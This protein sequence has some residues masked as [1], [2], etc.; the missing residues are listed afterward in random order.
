MV[1][2]TNSQ[3][4][5]RS[6]TALLALVWLN[7]FATAAVQ[8]Q[9][10]TPLLEQVQVFNSLPPA[11]Q[12]ALI[13]ELQSQL[14]P[15]QRQAI[16]QSL[17]EGGQRASQNELGASAN[18]EPALGEEP[19]RDDALFEEPDLR[20]AG[21]DTVVIQ[22]VSRAET[23]NAAETEAS[24]AG[25]EF[26]Q[27]LANANPYEL[28]RFGV[29]Y[30]PGV[31]AIPLAGL[32]V[33]EAT[34]RV[35]AEPFLSDFLITMT[36]LPLSPV[37]LEALKPFGYEIFEGVPSA[38]A[39]ATDIPVPFD[40][41]IGPGDTVYVQL[42]GNQNVEY[43][44]EVSREGV[45]NFPE[46]G[47]LTVSG[48]SFSDLRDLINERVSEQLIGVRASTT[49]GELRSI[50]IFVLGEV[51][52][53]GSYTVSGLSTM[54]NA[55]FASGGI[56]EI[57]SMRSIA[58][59]RNGD[60]VTTLD[61]YD[62]LLRGNTSGD[63]RLQPGDVIFVRPVGET[64]AVDGEVRRPAIYELRNER[65][66][67]AVVAL[68]GGLN[69]N[70]DRAAVKLER[71][72]P[73]RGSSVRDIDLSVS[74]GG[75]VTVQDG[76]VLRVQPNIEQLE[77]SMRLDGNVYQPGLYEWREGMTLGD[78]LPGPN[79]VLP[80]T[81]INYVLV[82]REVRPNVE[83]DVISADL[84]EIWSSD[85]M[86]GDVQ[87]A[88]R[89]TV[90][91]FNLDVGR[92]HIVQPLL[93]ELRQ[94][95]LPT[96]SAPAV[97]VG[98][99][100]RAAG[101]YP[102]EPDMRVSD[103]L[104]AGGGL[105]DA[106]YAIEAELTRYAIVSGQRRE[107]ELITVNLGALLRGDASADIELQPYDYLNIKE[108]PQWS[109]QQSITILGEVVFP[110]TYPIRQGETLSSVLVR[111]GGLTD[112]AFPQGSV[113]TREELRQREN[114]QLE[115]LASRIETELFSLQLTDGG[116]ANAISDGQTLIQELRESTATGR[117]VI[118]LEH[119][120]GGRPEADIVLKDGDRLVVPD[121]QQEVSVIGEVQYSTSHLFESGLSRDDYVNRSGGLT[122]RADRQR[123]YVVRAN[124]EVVARQRRWFSRNDGSEIRPGD[125]IVVPLELDRPLAR[126][127]AITQIIYNLAIAAAAVNS[128]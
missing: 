19:L 89:D 42:F 123:V 55:L 30:L 82:R 109:E 64:I 11:Q 36:R 3:A 74:A 7:L 122:Q 119:I 32:N 84:E 105:S 20:F 117:L 63:A 90:H 1:Q 51:E 59:V 104:R 40:Y 61:L 25:R 73:S 79:S 100:V 21:G 14:P 108:L 9:V 112:F 49:L 23:A 57:G 28:D 22:F 118:S 68:A 125:T 39:P 69:A 94:Q 124:G 46:I 110:G 4:H 17:Q 98:G 91:V 18:D 95:A 37:G 58:L 126:W 77:G 8:S 72:V 2:G 54:T 50:R 24:V 35:A 5:A 114:E 60:T 83:I 71:I 93:S 34:I 99:R 127:S 120:V 12:L 103:L 97:R 66:V 45:I 86:R 85:G 106:A 101:E 31:P 81:D 76:D 26:R 41:V 113:F 67:D 38:F 70:A 6:L 65:T 75:S 88:P 27:R 15:A 33:E 115:S 78:L 13:R 102:L 80:L 96:A 111:A 44:L 107:T 56:K 128:F 43:F 87:L 10:P 121:R 92:A 16:L 29:L 52:R 62:L 116:A 48:L 47:P 53:P